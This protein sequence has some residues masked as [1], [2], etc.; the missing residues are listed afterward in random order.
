MISATPAEASRDSKTS[1][2]RPV[3]TSTGKTVTPYMLC[4]Q[5]F[6]RAHPG[7]DKKRMTVL[8][9]AHWKQIGKNEREEWQKRARLA[10]E[11]HVQVRRISSSVA[12]LSHRFS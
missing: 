12:V 5:D 9:K 3:G 4:R 10:N 6:E 2:S 11:S 1:T 8:F 7:V